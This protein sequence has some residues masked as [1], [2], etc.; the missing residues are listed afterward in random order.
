[1]NKN[2]LGFLIAMLML[3][4]CSNEK[5]TNQTALATPAEI[6]TLH[7]SEE[8]VTQVY[9]AKLEGVTDVE[10]RPQ[11]SG[12]LEKILVEEGVFVSKGQ[13][14]FQIDARPYRESY[15][16][17][18][19]ELQAAKVSVNNAKIEL[20]KIKPLVENK[21]YSNYQLQSAQLAY[22]AAVANKAQ[23]EA[24]LGNAAITL[25]YTTVKAPVSGY[26]GRLFK[27]V[28]SIVAPSD[29][30]QLTYLSDNHEIHAYFTMGE[31]DFTELK[32]KLEGASIQDKLK[33]APA[34]TL[35][36]A[37]SRPYNKEG[38]LD[39]IDAAFD[40][41][42]GAI[43]LRASF[44]NDDGLLKSGNSGKIQLAFKQQNV[45]SIPQAATFEI[46]D[47]VFVYQVD[48]NNEVHKAPLVISGVSGQHY[49]VSSGVKTGDRIVLKGMGILK[50]G[51][52]ISPVDPKAKLTK[53]N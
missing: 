48:K 43:T 5:E 34:A 51:M 20:D 36:L 17:A 24:R 52:K 14:L 41:N 23:A 19:A 21:V 32:E 4:A 6:I 2:Y 35:I 10:I 42:T 12:I 46:Q 53:V 13:P 29:V 40:K 16:T 9:P 45:V 38:K 49:F 28:G 18:L 30:Q 50:D 22:D 31:I 3:S 44:P 26:V 39:M 8:T 15:N 7:A 27:K 11:V 37:G 33:N 25:A 1:M 47:K